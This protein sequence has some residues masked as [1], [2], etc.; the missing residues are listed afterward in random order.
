MYVLIIFVDISHH[1]P[2]HHL[3]LINL[4]GK[5]LKVRLDI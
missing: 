5:T 3:V 1:L 4:T 2:S